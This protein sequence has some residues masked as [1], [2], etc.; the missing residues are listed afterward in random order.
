MGR[1]PLNS[2][3][4]KPVTEA[5]KIPSNEAQ[6]KSVEGDYARTP[7]LATRPSKRKAIESDENEMRPQARTFKPTVRP[8]Q[9]KVRVKQMESGGEKFEVVGMRDIFNWRSMQRLILE[10]IF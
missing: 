9:R 3:S 4:T 2:N 10:A 8:S 6:Q 7:K 1:H 5:V